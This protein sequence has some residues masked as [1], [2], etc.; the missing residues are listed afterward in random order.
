MTTMQTADNNICIDDR[1][2]R[3]SWKRVEYVIRFYYPLLRGQ[4]IIYPCVALALYILASVA[5][6]IKW[7][8]LLWAAPATVISFMFY[9][10]PVVLTR[11]DTRMVATM[12]PATALEKTVVL[13]GYFMVI[14]PLLTYGV[15]Y[16][17][18][19]LIKMVIPA[20]SVIDKIRSVKQDLGTPQ[21]IYQAS[22]LVPAVTCLWAVVK[23]KRNR[24]L[25]AVVSGV[26]AILGIGIIGMVYGAI[27]AFSSGFVSGIK[28]AVHEGGYLEPEQEEELVAPMVS[29][30]IPFLTAMGITSMCYV[31]FAVWMIYHTVKTRQN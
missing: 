3:F 12:L 15:Y 2:S 4:M 29:E 19:S 27:V 24:T 22:E 18:G 9:L 5:V 16:L 10:A 21:F 30:M 17:G 20:A 28:D 8:D 1:A 11:R 23:V 26:A 7:T 31:A 13:L 6:Y 14:V 25:K